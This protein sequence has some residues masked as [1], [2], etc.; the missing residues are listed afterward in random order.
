MGR[1]RP[2]K[3]QA[4]RLTSGEI[5]DG[6]IDEPDVETHSIEEMVGIAVGDIRIGNQEVVETRATEEGGPLEHHSDAPPHTKRIEREQVVTT[7]P[8]RPSCRCGQTIAHS[9]ERGLAGPRGT[10]DDS[11]SLT[12]NRSM[13]DL[14]DRR[15][16]GPFDENIVELKQHTATLPLTPA[17]GPCALRLRARRPRSSS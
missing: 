17:E 11:G 9:E 16:F 3:A 6:S 13:V 5:V 4:L 7:E 15:A 14:D 2:C 10:N 8:N 1:Q 12:G